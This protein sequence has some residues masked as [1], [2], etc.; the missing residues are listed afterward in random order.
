MVTTIL[1]NHIQH[2]SLA[3]SVCSSHNLI[4]VPQMYQNIPFQHLDI[5]WP[6]PPLLCLLI[7]H[8]SFRSKKMAEKTSLISIYLHSTSSSPI[9]I[10]SMAR[11]YIPIASWAF[12]SLLCNYWFVYAIICLVSVFSPTT[13]YYH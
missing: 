10:Q 6:P 13:S 4:L 9:Y 2:F 1:S 12:S 7:L 11:S 3:K 5:Y 8:I